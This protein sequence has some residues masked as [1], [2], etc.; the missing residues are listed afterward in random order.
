MYSIIVPAA[1]EQQRRLEE[2]IKAKRQAEKK[3][4]EESI[5]DALI[6]YKLEHD[7]EDEFAGRNREGYVCWSFDEYR[8]Y[9]KDL[10]K[11]TWEVPDWVSNYFD[12][13]RYVFDCCTNGESDGSPCYV[14][15]VEDNK[16][17]LLDEYYETYGRY[18]EWLDKTKA[19]LKDNHPLIYIVEYSN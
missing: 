13:D 17:V 8:D 12:Y 7:G 1:M 5:I 18:Y 11:N 14:M 2:E 9:L 4:K 3:A 16:V 10:M 19:F 15:V 6:D